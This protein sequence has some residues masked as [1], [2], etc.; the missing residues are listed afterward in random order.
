MNTVTRERSWLKWRVVAVLLVALLSCAS[1]PVKT[2][3]IPWKTGEAVKVGNLENPEITEASGMASSKRSPAVLWIINDGGNAPILY[4]VGID[5]TDLGRFWVKDA[6]NVDWEA[7][8]SFEW[9]DTAYLLIADTGDNREQR[10]TS[11]F[12]V[13]KEPEIADIGMSGNAA[14]SI[15]WRV[16]FTYTDGPHDCEAVAVDA[17]RNRVLLISK[18]DAV[19]TLYELRLQPTR[20]DDIA[21]ARPLTPMPHVKSPTAMDLSPDGRLAAVL[22]Y[23]SAYLFFRRHNEDW[24][25]TF[26]R[27]PEQMA[28]VKLDQ[29]EAI[30]F[31]FYGKSIFVTSENIPAPLVRIHFR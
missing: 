23:E 29:Q 25:H 9:Q 16:R 11:S 3:R 6:D 5:G 17:D 22:T 10:S 2:A 12:Y 20:D 19:P 15:A 8:A 7:L 21:V 28:L 27:Q 24:K 1:E 14:V 31:G 26:Q 18:R 4:A 13:V 30:C